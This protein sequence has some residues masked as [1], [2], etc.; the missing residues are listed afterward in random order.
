ME[1]VSWGILSCNDY[2]GSSSWGNITSNEMWLYIKIKS[3]ILRC[4]CKSNKL[5]CNELFSCRADDE[6]CIKLMLNDQ[7]IDEDSC[8]SFTDDM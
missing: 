7:S 2:R 5:F 8:K 3:T 1:R 6:S 4:N